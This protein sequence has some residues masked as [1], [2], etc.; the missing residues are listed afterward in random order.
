MTFEDAAVKETERLMALVDAKLAGADPDCEYAK[1]VIYGR[2]LMAKTS[3]PHV[4]EKI[5]TALTGCSVNH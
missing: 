3:N 4:R 5:A 1:Q 2:G